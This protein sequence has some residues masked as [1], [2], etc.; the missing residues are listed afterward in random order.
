MKEDVELKEW[1]RQWQA[2][3]SVPSALFQKQAPLTWLTRLRSLTVTG[4]MLSAAGI[5]IYWVINAQ[6]LQVAVFSIWVLLSLVIAWIIR[7]RQDKGNWTGKAPNTHV[8]LESSVRRR[9]TVLRA[10]E[11]NCIAVGVQL[12]V[13]ISG[14][15]YDAGKPAPSDIWTYLTLTPNVLV[16]ALAVAFFASMLR[17]WRIQK[18][19]LSQFESLQ[20]ELESSGDHAGVPRNCRPDKQWLT[21]IGRQLQSL[22][23]SLSQFESLDGKLNRKKKCRKT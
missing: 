8:F 22:R 21:M 4:A 6:R 14:T 17:Y 15:H 10:V 12:L 23:L 16:V 11:L 2:E 3:R 7:F 9:R 5:F 18:S 1:R 19:Q 20:Q 13:C